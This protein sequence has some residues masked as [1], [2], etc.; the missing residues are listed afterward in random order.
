MLYL[1]VGAI[2]FLMDGFTGAA[3]AILVLFA[4]LIVLEIIMA[5]N[6]Y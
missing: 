5:A 2:G 4:G 1:V 6:G 3:V